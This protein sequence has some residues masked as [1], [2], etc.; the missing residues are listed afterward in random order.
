M[1]MGWPVSDVKPYGRWASESSAR[2]NI[3]LG[4]IALS[5]LQNAMPPEV[6]R[7]CEVLTGGCAEAF[8]A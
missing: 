2:E 1:E 6:W 8:K 4:E 7:R 5:R 3:R